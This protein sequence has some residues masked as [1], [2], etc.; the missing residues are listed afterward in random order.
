MRAAIYVRKALTVGM[1]PAPLRGKRNCVVSTPTPMDGTPLV[2]SKSGRPLDG[3]RVRSDQN[4]RSC[5]RRSNVDR[6]T[7]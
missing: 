6:L 7:C 1:S 3:P 2:C 4:G 5:L